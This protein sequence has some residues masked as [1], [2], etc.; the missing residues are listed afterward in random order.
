VHFH[1]IPKPDATAGLGIRWPTGPLG[2]DAAQLA[3]QL[4]QHLKAAVR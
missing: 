3:E 1:I 2:T 4:A